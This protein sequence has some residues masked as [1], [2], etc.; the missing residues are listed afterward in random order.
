MGLRGG[1][2]RVTAPFG[3]LG[4]ALTLFGCL[5]Q[6]P[7]PQEYELS[8]PAGAT[9]SRIAAASASDD[10]GVKDFVSRA[11]DVVYFKG[12]SAELSPDAKAILQKQIS[13]LNRHPNYRVMVAGHADE[14]GT[15]QHNLSVGARR[16]VAVKTYLRRNGLRTQRVRTLSYGK[17]RLVADCTAL[18]C[19][20]KNRRAQTVVSPPESIRSAEISR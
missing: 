10:A 6:D 16:A 2:G 17:E 9:P 14:W 15:L 5:G 18:K 11:G 12:D 1:F 3:A 13:W 20:A 7:E 19:R 4:L 8:G